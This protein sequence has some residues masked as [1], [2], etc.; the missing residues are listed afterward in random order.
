MLNYKDRTFCASPNCQNACGRKMTD[1]ERGEAQRLNA[2]VCWGYFCDIPEEF[3]QSIK[4]N[5]APE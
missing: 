4:E 5:E 3:R 1:A 2:V